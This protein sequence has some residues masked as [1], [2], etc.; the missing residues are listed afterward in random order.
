MSVYSNSFQ[1]TTCG[2]RIRL[3][4][5]VFDNHVIVVVDVDEYDEQASNFQ[6][7]VLGQQ[8]YWRLLVCEEHL[9][10]IIYIYLYM[11]YLHII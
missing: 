11:Y 8:W 3:F 4:N 2:T 1:L 7:A 10:N 6:E 5:K 9:W